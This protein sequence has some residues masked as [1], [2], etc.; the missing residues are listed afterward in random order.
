M[1]TS[2]VVAAGIAEHP[3]HLVELP[4]PAP[5]RWVDHQLA[6]YA[7]VLARFEAQEQPMLLRTRDDCR[8]FSRY[9][10]RNNT[11]LADLRCILDEAERRFAQMRVERAVHQDLINGNDGL[12]VVKLYERQIIEQ[13]A[14]YDQLNKAVTKVWSDFRGLSLWLMRLDQLP[15]RVR[16]FVVRKTRALVLRDPVS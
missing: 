13:H 11:G 14:I 6:G 7:A 9:L 5:K 16:R 2:A 15:G 8:T 10:P 3:Q 12:K 4:T 1:T